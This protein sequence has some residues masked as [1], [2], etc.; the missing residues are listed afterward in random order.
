MDIIR[1][2]SKNE[3]LA[4]HRFAFNVSFSPPMEIPHVIKMHDHEYYEIFFVAEGTL[5]HITADR[6]SETVNKQSIH[7]GTLCFVKPSDV[8][9][10]E[11]IRNIGYR[12][13]NMKIRKDTFEQFC[14]FVD[15]STIFN[16]S[17]FPMCSLDAAQ[18]EALEQRVKSVMAMER[19]KKFDAECCQL[20]NELYL[21]FLNSTLSESNQ[22]IDYPPEWLRECCN[23][24]NDYENF[25][26]GVARMVELSGKTHAHLTHTMRR[27]MGTTPTE[28]INGLRIKYACSLLADS[29]MPIIDI[30]FESGFSNLGWFYE[31]FKVHAGMS[32]QQYRDTRRS[33]NNL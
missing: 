13:C 30:C 7:K 1:M 10:Y 18:T 9:C 15:G 16:S 4:Y 8:H 26:A 33:A 14:N 5:K 29:N 25:S 11:G 2:K 28:Y 19:N 24:M 21:I 6:S 20:L 22:M 23:K 17:A 32:P 12:M 31:K 3:G 27:T